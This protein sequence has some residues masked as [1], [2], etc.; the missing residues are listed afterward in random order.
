MHVALAD[1]DAGSD[2]RPE[3]F[4]DDYRQGLYYGMLATL[5][6]T[7]DMIR[8]RAPGLAPDAARLADRVLG[9]A[10]DLRRRLRR[11]REIRINAVR[12]RT[13]G[14]FHLAQVLYTGKD[15]YFIDFEGDP[16]R[17]I[18]ERRLKRPSMRDVAGMLRSLEYA[19]YTAIYGRVGASAPRPELR[20]LLDTAAVFWSR[21]AG[22]AYLEAY[23]NAAGNAPFLPPHADQLRVLLDAYLID[24]AL[25][26]IAYEM[27]N[28]PDALAIPLHGI[29]NLCCR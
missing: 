13:H 17:P 5:N 4:S 24:R 26:E 6:R 18:S 12:I 21:W 25:Y 9:C 27:E 20:P 28:R 23:L 22:A 15:F 14:A 8:Q 16:G 2:F 7:L 10:D 19:A 3:P 11:L 29:V 1:F